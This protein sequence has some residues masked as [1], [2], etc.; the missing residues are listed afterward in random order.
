MYVWYVLDTYTYNTLIFIIIPSEHCWISMELKSDFQERRGPLRNM[1]RKN[2][3]RFPICTKLSAKEAKAAFASFKPTLTGFGK[4]EGFFRRMFRRGP[5]L[6]RK[7]QKIIKTSNQKLKKYCWTCKKYFFSF[8]GKPSVGQTIGNV[9]KRYCYSVFD[10]SVNI[11]SILGDLGL[12]LKF[13]L[14]SFVVPGSAPSKSNSAHQC[15]LVKHI[16]GSLG[17]ISVYM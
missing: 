5:N 2:P 9:I 14:S 17:L 6:D 4:R 12:L 1:R 3:S 16:K 13:S 8:F 10:T 15:V 7:N 11:M